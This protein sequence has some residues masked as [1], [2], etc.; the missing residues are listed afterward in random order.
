MLNSGCATAFLTMGDA[1]MAGTFISRTSRQDKDFHADR[2]AE[3]L[4]EQL[5]DVRV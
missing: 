5:F 4:I 2:A 3:R 1:I